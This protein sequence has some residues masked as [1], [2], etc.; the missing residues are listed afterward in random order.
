MLNANFLRRIWINHNTAGK[1]SHY[2]SLLGCFTLRQTIG[3][4]EE[5]N[6]GRKTALKK[7]KNKGQGFAF[8]F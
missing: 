7:H 2:G 3:D 8:F 4:F 5:L 6:L 1:M